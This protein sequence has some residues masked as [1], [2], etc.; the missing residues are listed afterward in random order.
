MLSKFGTLVTL[1]MSLWFRQ[2]LVPFL[3]FWR[4]NL[5]ICIQWED[6]VLLCTEGKITLSGNSDILHYYLTRFSWPGSDK[7]SA[8][9]ILNVGAL[10]PSAG[11]AHSSWTTS[12]PKA[13][14]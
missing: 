11:H 5:F 9:A 3:R 2:S 8:D 7:N 6:L 13:Q 12:K 4:P 10:L 14:S 1:Y